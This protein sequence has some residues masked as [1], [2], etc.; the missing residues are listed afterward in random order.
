MLR[1]LRYRNYR[2]F[3]AGQIVSLTGTWMSNVAVSWLVYRLTG[4]A[5]LL[6][7][8]GF[9]GQIPIFLLAPVAGIFVDRWD[10]RQL[11]IATQTLSMLQS[12]ALAALTF[13]GRID[14]AALIALCVFQ[15]CV[16]AFDMPC[17]QAFAVEMI[18]KK[19]DLGNA[20]ALNSSMVN[21]ARL[22]GPSIGGVVIAAAGEGWCF[23]ID[24]ASFSAVIGALSAM[25]V[26]ERP[27]REG[28]QADALRQMRE[29][30]NYAF[31]FTPIRSIILLM[32]L[33]SLTGFP[34]MVLVPVFTGEI[35]RGGPHTLGFLMTASGCGALLGALWLASRR[36]VVGLERAIPLAAGVLG[37]GLVVFCFARTM[38][39]SMALMLLTGFGFII[40]I[41]AGNTILQTIVEDDKRGRVMSFFTMAFLGAAPFGSLVAGG[42][43]EA[44]GVTNTFA[45]GGSCCILGALWF[46]R[47]LPA[48]RKA[49]RPIYVK[50][51]IL[52]E[53]AAGME[54]AAE[55]AVPPDD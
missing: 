1:A 13:S 24:G 19:E 46:A 25:R 28:S 44:I 31:G 11:L 17:R 54:S 50:M 18:D 4:S 20:I 27:A 3:F 12:F 49:V 29:G 14:I 16:N 38:W 35:L 15:G 6:G 48:L 43:A 53:L 39:L 9:S 26:R 41:A 10:R 47:E 52:P 2:L 21:V 34:F 33:V 8:V 7:V 22:L 55:P 42:M 40:Q 30:W 23:F 36:T 37:A 32:A 5:M 45:F 51:G